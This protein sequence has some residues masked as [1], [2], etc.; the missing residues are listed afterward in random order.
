MF[1]K[2]SYF[3]I[4]FSYSLCYIIVFPFKD[5]NIYEINGS[6]SFFQQFTPKNYISKISIGSPP[7]EINIHLTPND[8]RFY[9]ANDICYN[10]SISFYNYS[11]SSS[12]N[13]ILPAISPFDDL[14]DASF[15]EEK[16]SF[17]DD[18]NLSTSLIIEQFKFYFYKKYI[19]KENS[20]IFCGIIGL[21]INRENLELD[22]YDDNDYLPSIFS[23]LK[24]YEYITKYSWTYEYF[25]KNS[26]NNYI[27]KIIKNKSI[28]D[29]YDGLII[30]GQYPH[31]Y[32]PS[33]FSGHHL[34][35][36]YSDKSHY[37]FIWN[38]NFNKIYYYANQSF[39]DPDK[40]EK[41]IN[42]VDRQVE[43]LFNINYILSTKEYF[44]SIKQNYF[45]FYINKNIC[46]IND[47]KTE[48]SEYQI[49]SCEKENFTN[50]DIKKF[51]SIYFM[52]PEF[53]YTF[54]LNYEELFEESNKKLFFLIYCLKSNSNLW[55]LGKLFLKKYH[56]S[57]NQDSN[58]I[59]FYSDYDKILLKRKNG[60]NENKNEK[61][62]HIN[63]KII[64]LLIC[65]FI[66]SL[67]LGV[68]IGKIIGMK[69]G[70]NKACELKD[71]FDYFSQ[72]DKI[73]NN[74][75]NIIKNNYTNI[76]MSIKSKYN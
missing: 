25:D 70:K 8:Y 46:M 12:F 42:L 64:I 3:I 28:I 36:I 52:H 2:Y 16:V 5:N 6:E 39:S 21:A 51:P 19:F 65:I 40:E 56:F 23:T 24:S 71:N 35:N 67:I 10:N 11:Q 17:Y 49:I 53:N 58:T 18:I 50:D 14:A 1:Y 48:S 41:I 37:K 34:N 54:V 72:N 29:E 74:D 15:V 30:I 66:F 68:L 4:L 33:M 20:N 59:H 73:I 22:Y 27:S 55:I 44:N 57:F 9:I 76:E 43:L 61:S 31:E 63:I 13:K 26:K 38:F 60:I 75:I 7:Q 45:D 62:H 47:M 32:N 69:K